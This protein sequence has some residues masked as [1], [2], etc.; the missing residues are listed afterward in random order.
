VV[1]DIRQLAPRLFAG[2]VPACTDV[3]HRRAY[4]IREW[5][6]PALMTLLPQAEAKHLVDVLYQERDQ[7]RLGKLLSQLWYASAML[8]KYQFCGLDAVLSE[9]DPAEHHEPPSL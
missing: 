2:V 3:E 7:G 5:V 4:G 8:A 1:E 6:V 9:E